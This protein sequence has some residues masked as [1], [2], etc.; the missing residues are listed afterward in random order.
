MVN[1]TGTAAGT[2]VNTTGTV[3]SNEG[4]TG[5]MAMATLKVVAP[6]VIAK[7]FSPGDVALGGTSTLTFTLTN[8]AANADPEN[9]VGF[10]DTFPSGMVVANPSGGASTCADGDITANPG[11]GSVT[12]STILIP[13]GGGCAINVNVVGNTAGALVNSVTVSST[14]GGVG[15]TAM[16]TLDVAT[17]PSIAKSFGAAAI[18]VGGSTSLGFTIANPASAMAAT[19][20]GF[21]DTLPSG[22]VVSTPNGLTGSCGGGTIT[23]TAGSTSVS[24]SGATLGDSASCTFS[25]NVTGTTPGVKNNS[26]TVTSTDAGTGNTATAS[27]TVV[28]P[29]TLTKAFGA[30]SA[31]FGGST[32]LSFTVSNP[33]ATVALTGVGFT[34]T[35]PSGLVVSTPAGLSGGCGGG[36]ITAAPGA[37]S[38]SMSG[39]SI[40]VSAGCTF[41]VNVTAIS[42]GTKVNTTS[43]V[44]SSNGGTGNTAT[45]TVTVTKAPTTTTIS[46]SP[47]NPGFGSP[48][49][50]TAT[51]VPSDPNGSG[52]NP[53]GTVSFYLNGALTPLAVVTLSAAGTAIFTTSGLAAGA[54]TVS[55]SYSGDTNFLPSTSTTSVTAPV[56]CTTTLTGTTNLTGTLPALVLSSGA[57]CVL[58]AQVNGSITVLKGASLDLEG[59]TV[60]GSVNATGSGDIRICAT[61]ASAVTVDGAN[62][63]V[64]VGDA[65]DGCATNTFAGSLTLLNDTHGVQAI[66]NIVKGAVTASG[67][68]GAGP[69]PDDTAPNISGN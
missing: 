66:D 56:A 68:S 61:S 24:L 59:S 14:N 34:D 67:N 6:P 45:A 19:G 49:T 69:F 50:F 15:N 35:L 28:A 29:P 32:A 18:A 38:L 36:S 60:T 47:S 65:K 58:D 64:V 63:F 9:G 27:I 39:A 57:T 4:G 2:Q 54:N 31:P 43:A 41:G 52:T 30:A 5:G 40:G 23:A 22:L 26:V 62:G 17:P 46:V 16:A 11:S 37:T 42:A 1:V 55:A 12:A 7:S 10:V 13:V 33:N 20:L 53:T 51:V 48:A 3:S 25:V 8:P 21:T 44:T